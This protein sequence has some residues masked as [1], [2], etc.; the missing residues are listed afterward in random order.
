M[1]LLFL[2]RYT[3][4]AAST[5]QRFLQ[6]LSYY[7][8]AE[9][10]CRVEPLFGAYY[11]QAYNAGQSISK[12]AVIRDYIR[13]IRTVLAIGSDTLV[14]IHLELLPYIPNWL[15]RWL[16]YRNIPFVVDHDDAFF[17]NYDLHRQ[18]IVRWLFS[19]K[20]RVL[21]RLADHV[22]T[23]SPYLTT[24]FQ[25]AGGQVTEIPTS[26]NLDDYPPNPATTDSP[27]VIGWIGSRSTSQ[28]LLTVADALIQFVTDYPS[29]SVQL[30]GFDQAVYS[31]IVHP[32]IRVVDWAMNQDN[33]L[34][35][36]I[37]VGIMPLPDEPFT[38][39][40]C[41]FK[42]IQY[43]AAGKP[44][45]A[46]PLEANVKIDRNR[47]N[48]FARSAQDWYNALKQ[49]ADDRAHYAAVGRR[50]RQI[51]VDYYSITANAS[52]YIS[53]FEQIMASYQADKSLLT[54]PR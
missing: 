48:L 49:V 43:M 19:N 6:Y 10:T 50:N 28:Q 16:R 30:I 40:K 2:T 32:R 33:A 22:I 23:G 45:I 26:I 13:R 24:Y 35:Q 36:P 52:V 15:E 46:T 9:Y 25:Q 37:T 44:F 3:E 14:V 5:R 17:H 18:P 27:F 7:E 29:A 34:L 51:V 54:T 39:G 1:R 4:Q 12:M 8:R 31:Q 41:G 42:L 20:L 47:E 21:A 38:R 53:V 11:L